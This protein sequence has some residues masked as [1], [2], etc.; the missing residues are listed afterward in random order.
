MK[1]IEMYS[2]ILHNFIYNMQFNIK[3]I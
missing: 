2:F 1:M 3:L